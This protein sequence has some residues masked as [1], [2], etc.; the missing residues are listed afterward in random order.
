[1]VLEQQRQVR[2]A[3]GRQ[4]ESALQGN[5]PA[6]ALQ[7]IR[8]AHDIGNALQGVVHDHRELVSEHAVAAADDDISELTHRKRYPSLEAVVEDD[9]LP[10]VDPEAYRGIS[11]PSGSLT[12]AAWI[13][14]ILC[15]QQ[16]ARTTALECAACRAQGLE[17][18]GIKMR[19]A[20]L[21]FDVAIP[22]EAEGFEGPEHLIG[23]AG[24][25]ARA[26]EVFHAHEP[27]PTAATGIDEA[28]DG[29]Q[30]RTEV[31]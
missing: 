29:S 8:P 22:Q 18:L 23:A 1:G 17:R 30:Q 26:I 2:I 7:E 25:H 14:R 12:A 31:Q 16:P 6:G 24:H 10:L 4:A 3:R 9:G 13:A 20:A 11:R 5:L 15:V 19:P 28:A 27:A 21:V